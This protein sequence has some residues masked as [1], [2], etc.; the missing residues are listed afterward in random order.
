MREQ[1]D[2]EGDSADISVLGNSRNST[3]ECIHEAKMPQTFA[4]VKDQFHKWNFAVD[5]CRGNVEQLGICTGS[6]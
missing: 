2:G 1:A 4:D 6:C 5:F 3:S